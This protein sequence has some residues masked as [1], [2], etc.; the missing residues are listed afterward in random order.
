MADIHNGVGLATDPRAVAPERCLVFELTW[1][2][3][4]FN[5]AAQALGLEWLTTQEPDDEEEELDDGE[6]SDVGGDLALKDPAKERVQ[7]VYLTMP[8]EEAVR[9]LIGQWNK[10]SAGNS[11]AEKS[12]N[13]WKIF[14]YL[15]VLRTW[16]FE[17]RL[18][19][20]MKGY[21]ETLLQVDPQRPVLV[22]IDLWYRNEAE[23]RDQSFNTLNALLEDVGGELLDEVDIE[24]IRYQGALIRIPADVARQMLS[25]TNSIASLH[26]VMTI[27]PQ[28]AYES[29][30]QDVPALSHPPSPPVRT[31]DPAIAVVLDGYPVEQH[32]ALAGRVRVVEVD[33]SGSQVPVAARQHGT[34]MASLVLHGDLDDP[35]TAPLQ[36]RII[37]IP[38]LQQSRDLRREVTPE[39]KLPI[40]V[41][42]NALKAIANADPLADPELANVVIVNHSIC[43]TYAPFV[44]RPTPWATLLDYFSHKYRLLFVVSAGNIFT[45]MPT[46]LPNIAAYQQMTPADREAYLLAVMDYAHGTRSI[47]SPA[48]SLNALTVGA[49]H[50]DHAPAGA[51][52]PDPFP[53]HQMVNLASAIGFGV[54]RSVKPDLVERGGKFVAGLSNG[55]GGLEIHP[56]ASV[57]YGQ[58]VA[59]TSSVGN[60]RQYLRMAGTSNAAAMVTRNGH[61]IAAAL[62]DVF[63]VERLDWRDQPTR[64]PMLKALLVHGCSW[65]DVGELL[66]KTY[67]PKGKGKTPVRRSKISKF[68]GFG[69]ADISRVVDGN[70]NRITLLGDDMIK[71]GEMHEYKLPVPP[72]LLNNKELRS[73]TVTLSWTTPPTF[74]TTDHRAVVLKL[75]DPNGKSNY[76]EG[77]GTNGK[78]QP[79]GTRAARGTVIHV[80]HSGNKL[81]TNA[82][83]KIALCVQAMAKTGF[84][85]EEVPYAIAITIELAQTLRSQLYTEVQQYVRQR[86]RAR[87]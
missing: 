78:E 62:E 38:V 40:G 29:P 64:V 65:G 27:R 51:P 63:R 54:N 17:D 43:D 14:G 39:G 46:A 7:V 20:A 12:K 25:G 80:Q 21:V 36:R 3:A 84:E 2:V 69:Q 19:P 35:H 82:L 10:Y 53:N 13:L 28:S 74:T 15:K 41:I 76:W 75:C 33:L 50:S 34:A 56:R 37:S 42:Y 1:P 68:L 8:S 70:D 45:S 22:E 48:E 87:A 85:Q 11:P 47:L 55:A 32:E 30:A 49:V 66:D 58:K 59:G 57:H 52:E 86:T 6:V 60:T 24:E 18:D 44:R 72:S 81:M 73:V 26:D 9:D 67:Q 79:P 4:E 77:V 5:V 83:G 31:P 71:S 61:F 16:S 23:R